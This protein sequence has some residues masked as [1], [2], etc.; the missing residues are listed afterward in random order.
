MSD[1]KLKPCPFCGGKAY[2]DNCDGIIYMVGCNDCCCEIVE[3]FYSASEAVEAWNDRV[4]ENPSEISSTA[5]N[6]GEND[7]SE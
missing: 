1:V 4:S 5:L 3:Y 6:S 2:I 7:L